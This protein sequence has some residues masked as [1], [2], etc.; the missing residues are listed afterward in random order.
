MKSPAFRINVR[1]RDGEPYHR[2]NG[3]RGGEPVDDADEPVERCDRRG[4][5]EV[6]CRRIDDLAP[7]HLH[8]V[9]HA[10]RYDVRHDSGHYET[11]EDDRPHMG[12]AETF[13]L[14]LW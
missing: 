8:P 11:E 13:R 3:H 4:F 2:H 9:I 14:D 10:R 7:C 1:R 12:N 6:E 5:D